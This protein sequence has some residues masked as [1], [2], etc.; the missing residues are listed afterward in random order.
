M[1]IDCKCEGETLSF[2]FRNG[3]EDYYRYL[4]QYRQFLPTI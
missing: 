1:E 4:E 3:Q 2:I